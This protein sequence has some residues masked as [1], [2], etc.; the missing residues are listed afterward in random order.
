MR[1][2]TDDS[3][4]RK[5]ICWTEIV[6]QHNKAF[7]FRV[8]TERNEPQGT[9]FLGPPSAVFEL[10]CEIILGPRWD[11]I[12]LQSNTKQNSYLEMGINGKQHN[13][14]S[15]ACKLVCDSQGND[16]LEKAISITSWYIVIFC[17]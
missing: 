14:R 6:F 11:Q 12:P 8:I 7:T 9:T 2:N 10:I 15:T 3:A 16:I 4:M 1:K 5:K 17:P 13:Q